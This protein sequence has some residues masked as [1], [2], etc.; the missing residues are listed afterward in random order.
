MTEKPAASPAIGISLQV[1]LDQ[2]RTLVLQAHVDRQ[3]PGE[4]DATLDALTKAADRQDAKYSLEHELAAQDVSLRNLA[5]IQKEFANTYEAAKSEWTESGRVGD[6]K[7]EGGVAAELGKKD[8]LLANLR[9]EI[10]RRAAKI[11]RLEELAR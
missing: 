4:L 7:A 5:D 11:K 10:E 6:F 9:Q 8:T 1:V 3:S 2:N